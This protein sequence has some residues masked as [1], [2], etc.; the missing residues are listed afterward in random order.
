[1]AVLPGSGSARGFFLLKVS[2]FSFPQ[3][4]G[5]EDGKLD[6]SE[7]LVQSVGFLS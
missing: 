2:F 4:L 7:V 6:Q 1:M 5:A 3:S